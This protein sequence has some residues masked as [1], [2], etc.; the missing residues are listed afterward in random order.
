MSLCSNYVFAGDDA[1]S[2]HTADEIVKIDPGFSVAEFAK[3]QPYKDPERLSRIV[4]ALRS[5]GLPD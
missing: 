4:D 2:R 3:K 1:D 5:A